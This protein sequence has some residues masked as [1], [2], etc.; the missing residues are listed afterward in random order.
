MAEFKFM[1]STH[2]DPINECVEVARNIP[3]VVAV[4]DSKRVDGPVVTVAAAAWAPFLQAV[5]PTAG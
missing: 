3:G 1:K 5:T 4:R 2:S